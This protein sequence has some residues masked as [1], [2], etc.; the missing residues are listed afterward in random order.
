VH[1][2][3]EYVDGK[4]KLYGKTSRSLRIVPLP[5]R[6]ALALADLPAQLRT[7]LLFPA[8]RGGHL[9]LQAWRWRHWNPALR[10]AGVD[11]RIPYALRHTY[12]SLSI[13]AGV[14]LFELSRFMGT[15]A[16]MIDRTSGHLLRDAL[17]RTRAA[18]DAF[19]EVTAKEETDDT[20]V[21]TP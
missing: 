13:A 17:E 8:A 20:D 6:A 16:A 19:I 14:S 3:R 9:D 12:A 7:P 10:A 15:S 11:K 1:V 4:V 21:S 18:L 2:R 5:A